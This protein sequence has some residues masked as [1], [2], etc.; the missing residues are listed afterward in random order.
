MV[1]GFYPAPM[2]GRA[3]TPTEQ[4]MRGRA[5]LL[6][7]LTRRALLFDT[8]TV[9]APFLLLEAVI[10]IVLIPPSSRHH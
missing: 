2:P 10:A 3:V 8:G 5:A 7:I 6:S 1:S 4:L 9:A